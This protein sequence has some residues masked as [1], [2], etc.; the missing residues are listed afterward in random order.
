MKNVKW[1]MGINKL[2]N[3]NEKG[4]RD[5]CQREKGR[6]KNGEGESDKRNVKSVKG[7]GTNKGRQ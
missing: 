5:K 4:K 1:K 7:E 6:V 2:T 3:K